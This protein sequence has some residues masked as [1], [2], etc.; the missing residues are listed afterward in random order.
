MSI[1]GEKSRTL[2]VPTFIEYLRCEVTTLADFTQSCLKNNV[3]PILDVYY[4]PSVGIGA[5]VGMF[6]KGMKVSCVT[7]SRIGVIK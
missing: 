2:F 5:T 1:L 7:S 4:D 6:V 3:D